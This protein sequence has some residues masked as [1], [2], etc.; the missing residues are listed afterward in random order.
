MAVKIE[1]ACRLIGFGVS[2]KGNTVPLIPGG[3]D[4]TGHPLVIFPTLH[5]D[6]LADIADS[7]LVTL[8]RYFKS[9]APL[10]QALNGFSYLINLQK[11]SQQVITK[12]TTGLNTI[13]VCGI[14]TVIQTLLLLLLNLVNPASSVAHVC[15]NTQTNFI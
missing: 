15:H 4:K 10:Q 2:N 8:L 5:H 7:D 1:V 11:A 3:C 12:L 14:F 6:S 9:V 13:Q